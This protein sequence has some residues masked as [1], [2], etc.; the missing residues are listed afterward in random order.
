MTK[1]TIHATDAVVKAVMDLCAVKGSHLTLAIIS[2][3][4]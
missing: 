2:K 1:F 4:L 3:H